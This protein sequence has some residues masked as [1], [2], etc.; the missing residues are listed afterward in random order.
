MDGRMLL[1]GLLH[2]RMVQLLRLPRLLLLTTTT[3][4]VIIIIVI[5]I[6]NYY[7]LY[8]YYKFLLAFTTTT[9]ATATTTA[10]A[11]AMLFTDE[12]SNSLSFGPQYTGQVCAHGVVSVSDFL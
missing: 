7:Y 4:I 9:T 2:F 1:V 11:P 6:T 5:I 10:A 12:V 3:I 8:Y